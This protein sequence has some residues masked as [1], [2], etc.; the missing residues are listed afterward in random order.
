MDFFRI[1]LIIIVVYYAL[2][3]IARLVLPWL[4]KR[5]VNH[6]V[7]RQAQA[8]GFDPMQNRHQQQEKGKVTV[9]FAQ[10]VPK[11]KKSDGEYVDFEEVD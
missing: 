6:M 1:I 4:L 10:R 2:K 11:E 5:F 3:L 7:Q 9:D 8:F